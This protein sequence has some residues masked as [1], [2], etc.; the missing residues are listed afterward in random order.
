[1]VTKQT[2]LG[3]VFER[4]IGNS[5]IDVEL[6][7]FGVQLTSAQILALH[8]TPIQVVPAPGA[9]KAVVIDE[10][11]AELL[12]NSAAYAAIATSDDLEFRYTD[13]TG[14]LI[15]QVETSNFLNQTANRKQYSRRGDRGI[16]VAENAPVVARLAGAITTGNSP[17]N[18]TIYC[19]IVPA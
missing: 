14:H 2:N 18:L 6:E 3:S 15:Y 8:T 17:L 4:K 9:G 5:Q 10:M 7:V 19:R 11:I 12:Y 13:A 1:M 16:V